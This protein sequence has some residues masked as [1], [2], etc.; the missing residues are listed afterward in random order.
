MAGAHRSLGRSSS[1]LAQQENVTDCFKE[2]EAI[3]MPPIDRYDT[4]VRQQVNVR[5]CSPEVIVIAVR[6]RR[7]A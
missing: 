3:A 7:L 2:L 1:R 4:L 6:A 5:S